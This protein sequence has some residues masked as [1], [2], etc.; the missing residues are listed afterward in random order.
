MQYA[1]LGQTGVRVSRVSLGTA[2]FGVAPLAADA[3]PLV[4]RAIELGVNFFDTANSYGMSSRFDRPGAPPA[5]ERQTSEE[6]L[7]EALRGRRHDVVLATKAS[8][9][10]GQGP[11]DMGL[12]RVHLMRQLEQSLR[13]LQTDYVDLYYAHHSDPNTAIEDT[14]ATFDI[15]IRQG[16][17]RYCALSNYSGLETADAV[18]KSERFLLQPP[19]CLQSAYNF[20]DRR[21]ERDVLPAA[22]L[23]GLGFLAF[24]PIA[25]GLLGGASVLERPVAG[26]QRWGGRGFNEDE[27]RTALWWDGFAREAAVPPGQLAIQWLLSRPALTGVI[28]GSE[29]IS[30]LEASCAAVDLQLGDDLFESL[31]RSYASA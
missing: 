28:V 31:E 30:S 18:S 10:V 1:L 13:R 14:L 6:I 8:E 5:S 23:Y 4:S 11:N 3:G 7:G 16:K 26:S 12:S 17:V 29:R 25:G 15:M 20:L 27:A 21:V 2:A 9:R 24:S 19:V 22:R